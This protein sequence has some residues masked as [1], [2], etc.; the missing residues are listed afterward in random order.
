MLEKHSVNSIQSR[1]AEILGE[2]ED[3]AHSAG[4]KNLRVM[5]VSK[6]RTASEI[7][8]AYNA[9]IRLF[10]EN[11]VQEF[12]EKEEAFFA[13]SAEVHLIG[14][15]QRNKAKQIVGRVNCIES[16]DSLR[17]AE[18]VGAIASNKHILQ[19]VLIEVN[20]GLDDDKFGV[21]PSELPRFC[22]ALS[23]VPGIRVL[24]LMTVPPIGSN[25]LA[26]SIFE[27]TRMLFIDIKDKKI[28]N[29]NMNILSMGMS[30]DYKAAIAAGS[31]LIR[32]GTALF[33]ER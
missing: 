29:I 24:G 20:T 14:H 25:E 7:L 9:G 11:R 10:G 23:V 26:R 33:G 27:R 6:T 21:T 15:L 32:V 28:D 12:C 19:D 4:T 5:A 13:L 8:A 3:L 22:E 17:I 1:V 2:A 30:S 31:N 16:I 18:T